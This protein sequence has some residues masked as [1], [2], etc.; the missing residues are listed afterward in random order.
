MSGTGK[1]I[2]N[3][4]E[5]EKESGR[6]KATGTSLSGSMSA[7]S[8]MTNLTVIDNLSNINSEL[9]SC[10]SAFMDLIN[11]DADSITGLQEAFETFDM[12]T[13]EEMEIR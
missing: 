5:A 7:S 3:G 12:E 8:L 2:S 11:K 13:A 6:L 9:S 4:A 10:N 1:F